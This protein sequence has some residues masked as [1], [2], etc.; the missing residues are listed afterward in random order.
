[1]N[2]AQT[3]IQADMVLEPKGAG[4]SGL[5]FI[6]ILVTMGIMALLIVILH[7]VFNVTLHGWRKSDNILQVTTVARVV[8]QRMEREISSAVIDS[9]NNFYCLGYD[10]SSPIPPRRSGSRGAEFY[11]IAR[12]K[13]D[14]PDGSDLCEVGYWVGTSDAGEPML[15]RFYALD[16]RKKE[17][18]NPEFDFKFD[19]GKNNEFARGVTGL[20]FE[21][22]DRNG[23]SFSSW[24]S[25]VKGG[26][27][28][29]IKVTITV[30]SGKGSKATN[31][32]LTS[33]TFSTVISFL[34]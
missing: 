7:S 25:R 27:P 29:K 28:A 8:L 15:K 1:M 18:L 23:V 14:N 5:T 32:E 24:D 26:A 17:P 9:G 13:Q 20:E 3:H 10:K 12:V 6:E 16:D 22:F 34:Q 31:P 33:A 19:T 21:Y 11:F 4:N 2:P 30:E